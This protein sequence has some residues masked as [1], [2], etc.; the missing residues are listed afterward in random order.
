M[1]TIDYC[2]KL[3][4]YCL[5]L[6][7]VNANSDKDV[8]YL[9]SELA[10]H[11][12]RARKA[13]DTAIVSRIK[14][15]LEEIL[16]A[17]SPQVPLNLIVK[18]KGQ[19]AT[20]IQKSKELQAIFREAEVRD[21]QALGVKWHV[22]LLEDGLIKAL[23]AK[24]KECVPTRATHRDPDDSIPV[25]AL[26]TIPPAKFTEKQMLFL[27]SIRQTIFLP[28]KTSSRLIRWAWLEKSWL[29]T[30][31]RS[32]QLLGAA[33]PITLSA[34]VASDGNAEK[35]ERLAYT[36][37]ELAIRLKLLS[38]DKKIDKGVSINHLLQTVAR[39]ILDC[40]Q[41]SISGGKIG[42]YLLNACLETEYAS[43][44]E[45]LQKKL[46]NLSLVLDSIQ[47]FLERA[48]IQQPWALAT[49][50]YIRAFWR[51][52]QVYDT[53][54]TFFRI[55][56]KQMGDMHLL[57][58][59][60]KFLQLGLTSESGPGYSLE[61]LSKLYAKLVQFV[62]VNLRENSSLDLYQQVHQKLIKAISA[63]KQNQAALSERFRAFTFHDLRDKK[64]LEQWEKIHPSDVQK[65]FNKVSQRLNSPYHSWVES[66]KM[67]PLEEK[68]ASVTLAPPPSP[69]PKA[70]SVVAEPPKQLASPPPES[71]PLLPPAPPVY[72]SPFTYH[73][74]VVRWFK[75]D[76]ATD[77]FLNDPKYVNRTFSPYAKAWILA[78]HNFAEAV[79][80]F[81]EKEG[82]KHENE[83]SIVGEMTID[84]ETRRGLFTYVKDKRG[85]VY[86]RY[87][88]QKN[89]RE[90][91]DEYEIKGYY[92]LDFPPLEDL[93]R[94][95]KGTK[96]L[97]EA[98]VTDNSAVES[99]TN[100]LITIKDPKN[101]ATIRLC[102]INS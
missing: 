81:A 19:V 54:L 102:R 61:I 88:T 4:K 82:I 42:D 35:T 5:V 16:L 86:H 10:V 11:K 67:R 53:T 96:E 97:P 15:L 26:L 55:S 62:Q 70:A 91:T 52:Q 72:T 68:T 9:D 73:S 34:Y 38:C 2:D 6:S 95:E 8:R 33:V 77:P 45:R 92:N 29:E 47:Q 49:L 20:F 98:A 71:P 60:D 21:P 23:E 28:I 57:G 69:L 12:E 87:L 89:D 30:Y 66:E 41:N 46:V 56:R 85:V 43:N 32:M 48:N 44:C 18:L 39:D 64:P 80:Y 14:A 75:H 101:K 84:N 37:Q 3:K 99:I 40:Q 24:L 36:A 63:A 7:I 25:A 27:H 58:S 93:L 51:E 76:S 78:Q 50:Q 59:V 83:L 94:K 90:L 1:N 13:P 22:S 31:L 65:L 17:P 74:R 79:D 100:Y